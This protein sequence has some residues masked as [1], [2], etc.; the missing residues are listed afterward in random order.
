MSRQSKGFSLVEVMIVVVIVG[1]LGFIGWRV[2]DAMQTQPAE[3]QNGTSQT[4]PAE[5]DVESEADLDEASQTLD[6]TNIEGSEPKQ[7]ESETTF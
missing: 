5:T 1:L 6:A 7:L 3:D 4:T 2:W